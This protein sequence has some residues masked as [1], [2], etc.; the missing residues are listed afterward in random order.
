L[1]VDDAGEMSNTTIS[2]SSRCLAV[3]DSIASSQTRHQGSLTEWTG[4]SRQSQGDK[5]PG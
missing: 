3:A 4:A 5:I 1:A 2:R